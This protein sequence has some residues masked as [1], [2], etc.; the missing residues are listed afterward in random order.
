[1]KALANFSAA[2]LFFAIAFLT[3]SGHVQ[4][5]IHFAGVDN[6]IFFCVGAIT[7][8]VIFILLTSG[9]IRDRLKEMGKKSPKPERF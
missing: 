4:K 8:G 1:M 7:L 2:V 3:L 6:E 9:E 5:V